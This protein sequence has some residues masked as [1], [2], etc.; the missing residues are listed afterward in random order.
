MIAIL[1]GLVV[2]GL[3]QW[4]G[5]TNP[6][7]SDA[8][9]VESAT[10]RATAIVDSTKHLLA[11]AQSEQ[12][13]SV[14]QSHPDV[15]ITA[16]SG[17][18]FLTKDES[19]LFVSSLEMAQTRSLPPV[20]SADNETIDTSDGNTDRAA[21]ASTPSEPEATIGYKLPNSTD[22]SS[23]R[24]IEQWQDKTNRYIALPLISDR[25]CRSCYGD[26]QAGSI[27]TWITITGQLPKKPISETTIPRD[28]A[29]LTGGTV[30]LFILVA[31]ASLRRR[32]T[33]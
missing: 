6:G 23:S 25:E 24:T 5:S 17:R 21:C 16:P 30:A 9:W 33:A 22:A 13:S 27:I 11:K 20:Q 7:G 1:C 4:L 26:F 3:L 12:I 14:I 32:R 18:Y 28:L 31:A 8:Q 19:E 29:P 2:T 10:K 15:L